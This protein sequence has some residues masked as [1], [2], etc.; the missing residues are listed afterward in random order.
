MASAEKIHVLK[1]MPETS[2][3]YSSR[4]LKRETAEAYAQGE[5]G[6]ESYSTAI[7]AMQVPVLRKLLG[8]VSQNNQKAAH[9][10]FACGT[11]RITRL[12]ESIFEHVDALDISPAMV[13]IAR[14]SK[15]HARFFVGNI[16]ESPELC[17]GPYTSITSFRL[18][19]NLDPLLRIPVLTQ[20][21]HR[22][23]PDGTLIVNLHGNRHSLRHPAILWKRWKYRHASV[24]DNLMLNDMSQTEV[25]Q[26]LNSAGFSIEEIFGFGILPPTCYRL[27][28]N[29]LWRS[30]DRWLSGLDCLKLLGI[31][32]IFVCR[33]NN[34]A[35]S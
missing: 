14:E 4:F 26:C 11:G 27:P 12:V 19:L 7:W 32:L 6:Q 29:S 18:L 8:N 28:F 23:H 33:R 25:E 3:S 9:L 10:D 16:L 21:G 31:D 15:D 35:H 34:S 24:P 13:E 2:S 1:A 5:Y 22:L 17:P 30:L 20:L